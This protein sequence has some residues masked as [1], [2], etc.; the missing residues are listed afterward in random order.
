MAATKR[1]KLLKPWTLFAAGAEVEFQTS[2]ADLLILRGRAE[3]VK[4]APTPALRKRLKKV[5]GNKG[6]S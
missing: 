5:R 6:K 1:I 3:E 4:E 2:I